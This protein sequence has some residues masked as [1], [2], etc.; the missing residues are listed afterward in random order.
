[1]HGKFWQRR[2]LDSHG[3]SVPGAMQFTWKSRGNGIDFGL[4]MG[5]EWEIGILS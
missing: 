5:M 1:M 3:N 2:G 4:L